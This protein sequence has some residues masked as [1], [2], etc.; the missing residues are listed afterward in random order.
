MSISV[1]SASS[2]TRRSRAHLSTG[3]GKRSCV[4][5]VVAVRI[6][7]LPASSGVGP[8][9]TVAEKMTI[10]LS[11]ALTPSPRSTSVYMITVGTKVMSERAGYGDKMDF[12]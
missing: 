12:V 11:M 7:V 6:A 4:E 8:A 1:L 2:V 9:N 3:Y 5:V 10:L